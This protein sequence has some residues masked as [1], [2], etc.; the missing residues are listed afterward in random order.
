MAAATDQTP[1]QEAAAAALLDRM[2][3]VKLAALPGLAAQAVEAQGLEVQPM[4][5]TEVRQQAKAG[6]VELDKA[7]RQAALV[8][9]TQHRQRKMALRDQAAVEQPL[10]LGPEALAETVSSGRPMEQVVVVVV[11]SD[12]LI[13]VAPEVAPHLALG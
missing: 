13:T 10:G 12:R 5:K 11:A 9:W 1:R 3:L 4:V 8:V 6:T 7:V 2:A